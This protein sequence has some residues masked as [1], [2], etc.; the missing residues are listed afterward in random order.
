MDNNEKKD[1]QKELKEVFQIRREI[2]EN[3]DVSDRFLS[4]YHNMKK[5]RIIRAFFISTSAAAI[6]LF[7]VLTFSPLMKKIDSDQIFTRFY[8]RYDPD[9]IT[10]DNDLK[11]ELN[12][13]IIEYKTGR[14]EQSLE[15]FNKYDLE[16]SSNPAYRFYKS[17]ALIEMEQYNQAE[18]ILEDLR[19]DGD[20][21]PSEVYWYLVL[22]NLKRGDHLTVRDY[23]QTIKQIDPQAHKKECRQIKR[24]IR[25]R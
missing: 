23:I 13:G 25:F 12:Q 10:R 24:R 4:D 21:M 15:I 1:L 14:I 17:L 5:T 8:S 2:K 11:T 6:F 19:I 20:F 9:V 18:V 16:N 7:S 22:I 3:L